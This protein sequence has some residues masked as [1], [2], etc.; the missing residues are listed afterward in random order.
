MSRVMYKTV[1][2]DMLDKCY[3]D[4]ETIAWSAIN[5]EGS[6]AD[7]LG[8]DEYYRDIR[9]AYRILVERIDAEFLM[10][11]HIDDMPSNVTLHA[12]LLE[13]VEV[14]KRM[15]HDYIALLGTQTLPGLE[16]HP[17]VL[18]YARYHGYSVLLNTSVI[19]E[20]VSTDAE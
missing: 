11:N 12:C 19:G 7:V 1:L 5:M 6:S 4:H 2:Q 10:A 14:P 15:E 13:H 16:P 20:V 9:Y 8:T 3:P 17:V 18:F